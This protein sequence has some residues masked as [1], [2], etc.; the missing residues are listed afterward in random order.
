[1]AKVIERNSDDD[2]LID[3]GCTLKL[4]KEEVE[5]LVIL[6]YN[7]NL[8]EY[9]GVNLSSIVFALKDYYR[10]FGIIDTAG[11]MEVGMYYPDPPEIKFT[12]RSMQPLR[13]YREDD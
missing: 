5:A 3:K 7:V 11:L 13:R 1:M 9:R 6:L 10:G 12:E 4:E 2:S 8:L